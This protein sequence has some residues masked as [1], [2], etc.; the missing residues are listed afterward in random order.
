MRRTDYE[1]SERRE[2]E[3][4]LAEVGHGY[5][6]VAG[7][8]GWPSVVPL[9]FVYH[10][11][12]VYV[13]GAREGE[14][15]ECLARDDRVSFV[16]VRDYS[17]IPSY[18][19]DPRLACPATQYYQSVV[20]RG[21]ARVVAELE[22]K[23]EALQALMEK[24]QPEGGHEPIR[25]PDPLYRKSLLTTGVVAI[26]VEAMT[27]KFKFGQNLS[28]AKRD[29]VAERLATRGCPVDRETV[30]AMRKYGKK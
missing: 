5:L 2:M 29:D 14:K 1:M 20:I 9:N 15:M 18:F 28:S 12:K 3:A 8:D 24:L 7:P 30:E 27:A 6:G 19:R 13:H 21:R 4:L 16:V 22:E 26:E 17:V 10:A 25:A 11:G 23:A